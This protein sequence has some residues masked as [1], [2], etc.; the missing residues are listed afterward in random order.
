MAG[1]K[2]RSTRKALSEGHVVRAGFGVYFLSLHN[3]VS[4][5]A[6]DS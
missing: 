6:V 5:S 1:M 4:P 3:A 2:N